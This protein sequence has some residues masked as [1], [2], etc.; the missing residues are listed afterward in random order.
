MQYFL[1]AIFSTLMLVSAA[2]AG[3]RCSKD[4]ITGD[5]V[6]TDQSSGQS[7]RCRKDYITGDVV[8]N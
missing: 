6:C 8:C 1:V 5:V 2:E 4:Y 3:T 7:T